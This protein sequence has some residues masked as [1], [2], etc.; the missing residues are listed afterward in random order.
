MKSI[1]TLVVILTA[2][3]VTGCATTPTPR[4]EA[5]KIDS[6]RLLA[7]QEPSVINS[8]TITITRDSGLLGSGCYYAFWI[9]GKLSAR[10]A[11]GERASFSVLPGE[12]ILKSGRDPQGGGLCGIP[13][14]E[15]TQ[16]ETTIR[17]GEIKSFRLLVDLNG[18]T[19]IQ[20]Y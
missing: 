17:S 8:G 13:I 4:E 16:R 20:R 3:L 12:H 2:L 7:F 10:F 11:P 19:D 14:D 15:W 6:T 18:K 5:R 9:N 1:E